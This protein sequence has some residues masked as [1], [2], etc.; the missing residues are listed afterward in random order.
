MA[1]AA[2]ELGIRRDAGGISVR[3]YTDLL[4]NFLLMLEEIDRLGTPGKVTR[5]EWAVGSVYE[6]GSTL[7][8]VLVLRTLPKRREVE[9]LSIPPRALVSGVRSLAEVPEIPR[10]F[11]ETIVERVGHVGQRIG[12]EGVLALTLASV[13]GR[14]ET[15]VPLDEGVRLNARRAIEPAST[16]WSS[17]VGVLDVISVRHERR[18][19]GLLTDHGRAVVCDVK[20]LP[21]EAVMSAFEQRVVAAGRLKRN[22]SGQPV[23]LDVEALEVLDSPPPV[24]AR[25]LLGAAPNLTGGLSVEEYMAVLRGR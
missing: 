15:D 25:D 22:S 13:N 9:S 17:L 6:V 14:R 11:S 4:T 7:R 16:A 24:V 5:P 10:L 2:V 8:M 3:A 23:S 20:R 19:I 21:R 18:R 1:T 12:K